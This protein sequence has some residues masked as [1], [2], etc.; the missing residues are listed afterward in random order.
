MRKRFAA[1]LAIATAAASPI[2]AASPPNPSTCSTEKNDIARLACFDRLFPSS[3]QSAA[4]KVTDACVDGLKK[5]LKS[6]S[7]FQLVETS[8]KAQELTID[9]YKDHE[10]IRIRDNYEADLASLYRSVML[11]NIEAI[12]S[13]HDVVTL[14]SVS[15]DYDAQNG[16][17]AM[18]RGKAMCFV[19]SATASGDDLLPETLALEKR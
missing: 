16:F 17:G 18:L 11:D 6:P 7:T 15:I 8:E 12:R 1:F 19:A 13:K 9:E 10:L 14:F 3:T 2:F 4:S 5:T